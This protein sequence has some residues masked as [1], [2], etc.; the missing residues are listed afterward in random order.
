MT[1][2]RPRTGAEANI[3]VS[4]G[5]RGSGSGLRAG[6]SFSKTCR[7]IMEVSTG[8]GGR[9]RGADEGLGVLGVPLPARPAVSRTEVAFRVVLRQVREYGLFGLTLGR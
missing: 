7:A 9:E 1:L 5:G 2:H 4:V 8:N 3:P 6:K